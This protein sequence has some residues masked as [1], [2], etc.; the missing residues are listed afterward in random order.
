MYGLVALFD[1][2][3]E[4]IIK[5]IWKELQEKSISFY[6]NEVENRRPHITLASYKNLNRIEYLNQMEEFYEG[7]Q[8]ID[9]NFNS[10]GSFLNSGALFFSPIV[11]KE[12][13]ELHTSHHKYFE[14]FNDDPNSLYLPN[15]WIPHCTLANRLSAEKLSEAFN[16]C[17]KRNNTIT[18][19]IKEVAIID[20]SFKNKAPIIYS[21]EFKM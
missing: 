2:R 5:E 9:I 16:Y 19:K 10:I 14:K 7:K 17:S 18:G 12:L 4:K 1:E 3:T 15:S 8:A 21:K 13:I 11:T 20:V 6:A